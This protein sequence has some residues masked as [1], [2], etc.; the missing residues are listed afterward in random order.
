M[1]FKNQNLGIVGGKKVKNM[2]NSIIYVSFMDFE[3]INAFTGND[4]ILKNLDTSEPTC[5][6]DGLE[7][8][9]EYQS[10]LGSKAIFECSNGNL[11]ATVDLQLIFRLK[12]IAFDK[13]SNTS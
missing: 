10:L 11:V 13:M 8:F 2:S 6:I 9:G 4:I 7:F 5:I 12:K 3:D 1:I